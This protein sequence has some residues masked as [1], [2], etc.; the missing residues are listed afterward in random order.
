MFLPLMKEDKAVNAFAIEIFKM[1]LRNPN[2]G[3][4]K[5]H[6]LFYT[7]YGSVF[8]TSGKKYLLIFPGKINAH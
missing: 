1:A 2:F 7:K 4:R 8:R 3:G 6:P 5:W